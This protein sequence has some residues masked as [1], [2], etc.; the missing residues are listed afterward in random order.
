MFGRVRKHAVLL[1]VVSLILGLATA[2]FLLLPGRIPGWIQRR[3]P[4]RPPIQ[5]RMGRPRPSLMRGCYMTWEARWS[6]W[7]TQA[8]TAT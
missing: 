6:T 2:G 4:R 8:A 5:C 7:L 1:L 3:R